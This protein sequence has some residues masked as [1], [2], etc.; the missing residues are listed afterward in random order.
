MSNLPKNIYPAIKAFKGSSYVVKLVMFDGFTPPDS[1]TLEIWDRGKKKYDIPATYNE[2]DNQI[3]ATITSDQLQ[4]MGAIVEFYIRYNYDNAASVYKFGGQIKPTLNP[5]D[6]GSLGYSV[7]ADYYVVEILGV[8]IVESLVGEATNQADIAIENAGLTAADKTQTALDRAATESD[9]AIVAADKT[10]VVGLKTDVE[11][12]K[13]DVTDLKDQAGGFRNEA[14][15][16]KDSSATSSSQAAASLQGAQLSEQAAQQYRDEAREARDQ[17][18]GE[19]ATV[20]GGWNASTN[21]L[22]L[23]GSL[24]GTL[25]ANSNDHKTAAKEPVVTISVTGNAPFSGSNFISGVTSLVANGTLKGYNGQWTY[26]PPTDQAFTNSQKALDQVK[27]IEAIN[28]AFTGSAFNGGTVDLT[29]G[30][31]TIPNGLSGQNT[32]IRKTTPLSSHPSWRVGNKVTFEVFVTESQANSTITDR[33][34]IQLNVIRNGSEIAGV[35]IGSRTRLDTNTLKFVVEYTIQSGDSAIGVVLQTLVGT[36]NPSGSPR[37]WTWTSSQAFVSEIVDSINPLS[38]KLTDLDNKAA[39]NAASA[40][41]AS[42]LATSKTLNH[43]VLPTSFDGVAINGATGSKTKRVTV[44]VGQH[45][46]GSYARAVLE[47]KTFSNWEDLVGIPVT[48]TFKVN[49]SSNWSKQFSIFSGAFRDGANIDSV[50]ITDKSIT[51]ISSTVS[52]GKFTYIPQAGD[53]AIKPWIQIQTG[54]TGNQ[55]TEAWYELAEFTYEH[56][57]PVGFSTDNTYAQSKKNNYIESKV[58]SLE[59]GVQFITLTVSP[60]GTKQFLSPKL[61]N[62]SITDSS[63]LKWYQIQVYP[64]VYAEINWIVAPYTEVVGIARD[65]CWLKGE[66]PASASDGQI[67]A[68]STL[69]LRPTSNL[70]NLKITAKNMRYPV[71]DEFSGANP[72]AIHRNINCYYEHYGNDEVVAYRTANSLPAG[73]P[74]TSIKPYGYGS[75]SGVEVYWDGCSLVSA[76]EAFYVHSNKNFTRPNINIATGCTFTKRTFGA[77]AVVQSLGSGTQ[78]IVDFR[79]CN[80][81]QGYIAHQDPPWA[82][83]DPLKQYAD[84]GDYKIFVSGHSTPI[85]YLSTLRGKALRITGAGT[86]GARTVRVSGSAADVLFGTPGLYTERDYGYGVA[87]FVFGYWDIS[88]ILVGDNGTTQTNNTIGRRIGDCS[89][90]PKTLTVVVDGA[91]PINIV[92]NANLTAATNAT[93]LATINAALTG[94]ATADEYDLSKSEYYPEMNGMQNT[95]FNNSS[96]VT[97][98]AWSPLKYDTAKTNVKVVELADLATA[99]IGFNPM[100]IP[101]K[102]FGRVLTKGILHRGQTQGLSAA[103]IIFSS[104][105]SLSGTTAGQLVTGTVT[106]KVIGRGVASDWF[107]FSGTL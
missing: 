26:F 95:F 41:A 65:L 18:A 93:I 101:P 78:D 20:G 28:E 9:K 34:R 82:T 86:T 72:D 47:S 81:S 76:V 98:P 88:G 40:Q 43:S 83:T 3:L 60:D 46:A 31:F 103:T 57:A 68:N 12:I 51:S 6:D 44:P 8:D 13:S 62:D 29:A 15:T 21:V 96:T 61:A 45:G 71:H 37:T 79:N 52:V 11:N 16:F 22:S 50:A 33:P 70:K 66:L 90:T 67:S 69:W 85:G 64:G 24:P 75:S 30:S 36:A 58:A 74:W 100:P 53:T 2:T 14:E 48:F 73:S 25:T 35:A 10:I 107:E 106:N 1:L 84:H 23:S 80:F 5:G 77:V 39:T 91:A 19:Y 7:G 54:Q 27:I 49:K 99:F 59:S 63:P 97:I 105:I 56:A 38:A 87:S 94:V 32:F 102:S 55:S 4:K 92:F 17:S 42:N 89:V 104:A